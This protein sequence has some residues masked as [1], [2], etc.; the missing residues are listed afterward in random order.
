[1]RNGGWWSSVV[2]GIVGVLLWAG[3]GVAQPFPFPIDMNVCLR[4]LATCNDS[5]ETCQ[6]DLQACQPDSNHFFGDELEAQ[7]GGGFSYRDNSDGTFTDLNTG[8]MWERKDIQ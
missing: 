1:M 2:G 6:T 5:L 3:P 8:L 7:L 4:H